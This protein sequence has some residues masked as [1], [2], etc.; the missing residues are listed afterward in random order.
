LFG[1]GRGVKEDETQAAAWYRKAA[2]QGDAQAQVML[3]A[4]YAGGHGVQKSETEAARWWRDAAR[5][6]N[7]DAQN[8]LSQRGLKW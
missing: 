2:E 7:K 1:V 4:S 3:G 6:G 5:Q 8:S